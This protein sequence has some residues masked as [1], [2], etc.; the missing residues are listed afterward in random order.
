MND[1]DEI[2]AEFETTMDAFEET[3]A[4]YEQEM[5]AFDVLMAESATVTD[6]GPVSSTEAQNGAFT[7]AGA[8]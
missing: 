3:Y 2:M 5:E 8:D 4:A 6:H 1:F 7:P